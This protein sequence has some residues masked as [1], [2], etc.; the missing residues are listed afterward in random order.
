MA[1]IIR[2]FSGEPGEANLED[3]FFRATRESGETDRPGPAVPT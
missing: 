1:E 2:K 3:I